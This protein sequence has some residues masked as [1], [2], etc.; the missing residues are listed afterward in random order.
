MWLCNDC[1]LA[2]VNDDLTSL[3]YYY[4]EHDASERRDAI[5]SGLKRLGFIALGNAHMSF[6]SRECD[7]CRTYL[8]GERHFF[9]EA[10]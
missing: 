1:T 8:A 10:P 4:D 5:T 7:C 6:S 9:T 3:D 2:A